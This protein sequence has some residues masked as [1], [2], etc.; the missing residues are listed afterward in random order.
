MEALK[1]EVMLTLE[2]LNQLPPGTIFASGVA[3]DSE[4]GL[5][6]AGTGSELRWVA[7]RGDT[8]DWAIYCQ[9]ADKSAEWIKS[10]GDKV[11]MKE[12]IKKLVPCDD[13]AFKMY[14]H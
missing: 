1:G 14:R 13:E 9:F 4:D 6:M 8:H 12:H 11:H 2:E 5:F 10:H 3:N 7:V